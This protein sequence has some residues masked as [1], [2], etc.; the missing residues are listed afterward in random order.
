MKDFLP[1][2]IASNEE[3]KRII[4]NALNEAVTEG[5]EYQ[6]FV[7]TPAYKL[8]LRYAQEKAAKPREGMYEVINKLEKGE[9]TGDDAFKRVFALACV[10]KAQDDLIL[11][12]QE[13]IKL[14]KEARKELAEIDNFD[15]MNGELSDGVAIEPEG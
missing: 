14:G 7:A 2:Y 6:A 1:S 3:N 4:R 11:S 8:L 12:I 10:M 13:T 5:G 9:M 15:R